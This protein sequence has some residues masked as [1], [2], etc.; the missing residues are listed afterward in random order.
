L[1]GVWDT[2]LI[3]RRQLNDQRYVDELEGLIKRRGWDAVASSA[4]AAWAMESHALAK[5]VLSSARAE[6]DDAYYRSHL[7][8]VEERLARGGLRLAAVLN[9]ALGTP[10]PR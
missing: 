5:A 6:I 4:P 1:H 3:A 7:S 8:E 2:V 9:T 10:P